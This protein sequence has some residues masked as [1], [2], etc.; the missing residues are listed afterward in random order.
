[1][2]KAVLFFLSCGLIFLQSL[3]AQKPNTLSKE[4][5]QNGWELLFDGA[6]MNGWHKFGGGTVG[7]GWKV[8]NGSIFYDPSVNDG[9]DIVTNKEF[10]DFDL[11][12][13]WKVSKGANSGIMFYVN[14]DT[15]KYHAPWQTGPEMQVL[16]NIDAEDNKKANHLAGTL[17]DLLGKSE[18]SKPKPVGEWNQA[19]IKSVHGKLDL[20]LNGIHIVSTELWND[21]WEKMIANSKFKDMPGFGTFKKGHIDLQDHG[22]EVWFRNIRIR[23]L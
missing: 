15:T 13:E 12:L 16:D 22:H 5:K 17:Y 4:E 1:M 11:K 14:E 18:D 10:E 6:T 21:N 23:K 2:K 8:S 20:Y 3:F 7:K 19:E 9:G